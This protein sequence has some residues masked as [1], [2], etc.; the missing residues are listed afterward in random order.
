[1]TKL[2]SITAALM[3]ALGFV[4]SAEAVNLVSNPSFELPG[5]NGNNNPANPT[6]WT[7][8]SNSFGAFNGLN[9]LPLGGD[10]VLH[11]GAGFG[12]GGRY[13]DIAT[14]IG[15]EYLLKFFGTGFTSG[16][17]TQEG[18]V[19]VGTPGANDTNLA[20]NNNAELVDASFLVPLHT[21]VADWREFSFLVTAISTTTRI[22]F[23]NVFLG[24]GQ[25]AIN[26]DLVSFEGGASA[27]PEPTTATLGLIGIAGLVMRRRK[28]A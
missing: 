1:M 28:A 22:S 20:L 27:V 8:I 13:Q 25:N 4:T 12:A 6:D 18:L 16:L 9:E 26:V 15:E 11:P 19:Q 3:I 2:F 10:F 7:L 17:A 24:G 21:S 5:A 23:Q 14:D